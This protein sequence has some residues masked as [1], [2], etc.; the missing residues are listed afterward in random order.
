MADQG[1]LQLLPEKRRR[2]EVQTK[3]DM[4]LL[5][6]GVVLLISVVAGYFL[7]NTMVMDARSELASL[8]SQYMDINNERDRSAEDRILTL[9]RQ[10]GLINRL[11][12]SHIYWSQ[13]LDKL[14][15]LT[16]PEIRYVNL[17]GD[18]IANTV[19]FTINSTSYTN[20]AKQISAYLSDN[21]ILDV[22]LFNTTSLPN[23]LFTSNLNI[24]FD[25]VTFLFK[26]L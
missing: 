4:G 23:G 11:L 9:S 19:T 18:L 21:S 1:G 14:E 25:P 15:R 17:N 5:I 10:L 22:N 12:D 16:L 13:G 24:I 26:Q 7:L 2:V 20:L 6:F 8:D 3:G